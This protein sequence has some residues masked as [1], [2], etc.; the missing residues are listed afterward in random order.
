MRRTRTRLLFALTTVVS[1]VWFK[2]HPAIRFAPAAEGAP[3]TFSE[4]TANVMVALVVAVLAVVAGPS[5]GRGRGWGKD[6]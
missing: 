6:E 2:N 1:I 5:P 4:M 3:M